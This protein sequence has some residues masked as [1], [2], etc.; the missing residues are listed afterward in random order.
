MKRKKWT[1]AEFEQQIKTLEGYKVFAPVQVDDVAVFAPVGKDD[2][3]AL[4]KPNTKTSVKSVLFPQTE[5]LF[6]YKRRGK[7]A[8][9][10]DVPLDDEKKVVFGVRPC[11]V[12]SLGVLDAVFLSDDYIDPYYKRRR[13]NTTIVAAACNDPEPTCF[14]T[15]MGG[16]PWSREGADVFTYDIGDY[17][18]AESVTEKGDALLDA[19]GGE[20]VPDADPAVETLK[21]KAEQAMEKVKLGDLPSNL[22]TMFDD[23]RWEAIAERCIGCGVCSYICPTCHCF[24]IQDQA[25]HEGGKRVRN[26]DS[27]MFPIFSLHASGH[28]PRTDQHQRIR[29]RIMHKFSYFKENLDQVA[30]VGC[31]RCIQSC[32]ANIDI[33]E[34]IELLEAKQ[35]G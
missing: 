23:P 30:C 24:D 15:S 18:V 20:D 5:T 14:C 16:G 26:W 2:T 33:R 8:V 11:D 22:K 3:L 13:E 19:C 17:F 34:I 32:P 29:Q 7:N 28:N 21:E 12:A 1:K 6:C 10:E 27:C 35:D 9:I 31:G 4:D 25:G